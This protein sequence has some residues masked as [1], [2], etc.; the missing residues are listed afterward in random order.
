[1]HQP[2]EYCDDR[3]NAY[4]VKQP[5]RDRKQAFDESRLFPSHFADIH[6]E[7]RRF[8]C[9]YAFIKLAV[10]PLFL[11][12]ERIEEPERNDWRNCDK[13]KLPFRTCR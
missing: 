7:W 1:M 9:C 11:E 5:F 12:I 6:V 10:F 3:N 13:R 2:N 8:V 4:E